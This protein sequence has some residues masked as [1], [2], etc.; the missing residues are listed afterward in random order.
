MV[1]FRLIAA[2]VL[3]WLLHS[4][5]VLAWQQGGY[6]RYPAYPHPAYQPAVYPLYPVPRYYP[7]YTANPYRAMPRRV[8]YTTPAAQQLS[9]PTTQPGLPAQTS[10]VKKHSAPTTKK[11]SKQAFIKKLLPYIQR[12]NQRLLQQRR[13][14]IRLTAQLEQQH[15]LIPQQQSWLKKLARRYRVE[16]NPIKSAKARTELL[17]KVDII[18]PSL[19]LAQAANESGWGQSR[20]ATT[21]NNLFGIWT[22]D[23]DKGI[24]PQQRSAGKQ[25]LIRKFDHFGDSIAYYMH[26]LN[27]HPAYRK[28]RD[29]RYQ[30]RLHHQ[31][32]NGHT[33][34]DG[35][36][37]YSAKGEQYIDLIKQLIRQ[38]QLAELDQ[39]SGSA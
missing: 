35:L 36:A 16:G 37:L 22:Y 23:K 11:L 10:K 38:N 39:D 21:A 15:S 32:L 28:L 30:A 9:P 3:L 18:P 12:E 26:S 34:A 6:F 5:P 20:F 1:S 25:H 8:V 13:Q 14:L 33:L 19:A 29:L 27:A 2:L 31:P 7:G 4:N 17:K 24:V